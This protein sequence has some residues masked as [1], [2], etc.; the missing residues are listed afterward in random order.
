[1]GFGRYSAFKLEQGVVLAGKA[2]T[3]ENISPE[4]LCR[5]S[6]GRLSLRYPCRGNKKLTIE[7]GLGQE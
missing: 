5:V 3:A 1:M 7:E 2:D 6:L 4:A